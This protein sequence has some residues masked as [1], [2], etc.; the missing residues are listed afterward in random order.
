MV[1]QFLLFPP[2]TN[3]KSD[4]EDFDSFDASKNLFLV[5][6]CWVEPQCGRVTDDNSGSD[7]EDIP[8]VSKN[9]LGLDYFDIPKLVNTF[10]NSVKSLITKFS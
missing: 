10:I 3:L 2:T 5:T 6:E 7:L 9:F 8:V 4:Y 1:L